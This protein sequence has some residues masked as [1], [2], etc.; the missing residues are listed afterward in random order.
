MCGGGN[1]LSD[2]IDAVGDLGQ[3]VVDTAK[4]VVKSPLGKAALIAAGAYFAPELGA[5]VGTDGEVISNVTEEALTEGAADTA[6]AAETTATA[7]TATSAAETLYPPTDYSLT[8]AQGSAAEGGVGLTSG[9]G[10]G[11][12]YVGQAPGLE[13]M[14]GAQGLTAAEGS[15]LGDPASFIND[16]AYIPA[17]VAANPGT[18]SEAGVTAAD[19]TPALGD[20]ESFI[21]GGTANTAAGDIPWNDIGNGLMI[22]SLL[23]GLLNPQMPQTQAT[24]QTTTDSSQSATTATKSGFGQ[25]FG[26]SSGSQQGVANTL[27]TTKDDFGYGS[28]GGSTLGASGTM[29]A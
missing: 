10:E 21:N 29:L 9:G 1:P 5:W 15:V 16:P 11:L 17:E 27:L 14:G 6:A 2:A 25:A 23:T 28:P 26:G 13:E 19:A 12:Q 7:E 18:I 22:G 8:G 3:G 24:A 4:D 20:P